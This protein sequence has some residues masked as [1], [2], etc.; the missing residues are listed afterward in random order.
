M[1]LETFPLSF[2]RVI[3]Q[4]WIQSLA[5]ES[6]IPDPMDVRFPFLA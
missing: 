6:Q 5:D 1:R 2:P 3:A 4:S